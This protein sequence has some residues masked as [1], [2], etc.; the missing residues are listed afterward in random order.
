M[1][2][3]ILFLEGER[4]N[5]VLELPTGTSNEPQDILSELQMVYEMPLESLG[6]YISI[7]V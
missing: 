7:F 3:D 2:D 4:Q 5:M 6:E 1:L